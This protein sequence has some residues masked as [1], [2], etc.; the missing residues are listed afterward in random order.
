MLTVFRQ[1][2]P[3]TEFLCAKYIQK[4]RPKLTTKKKHPQEFCRRWRH[5]PT[6]FDDLPKQT[7]V[8]KIGVSG[9]LEPSIKQ[10][11]ATTKWAPG[12][13]C[14]A[15][16]RNARA[17]VCGGRVG[18]QP[19]GIAPFE[20]AVVVTSGGYQQKV[21]YRQKIATSNRLAIVL[22]TVRR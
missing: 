22:G 16:C 20:E 14:W 3:Q 19:L 11:W 13:G 17:C 5:K 6:R 10:W 9:I 15:L 1:I 8:R 18:N 21:G 7:Q 4:S 2:H 12:A